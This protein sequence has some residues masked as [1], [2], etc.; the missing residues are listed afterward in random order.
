LTPGDG[1][2]IGA[3]W[4]PD[5]KFI[6]YGS[7]RGDKFGIYRIRADS[8]GPPEM[9]ASTESQ[10]LP[11]S[12]TPDD[13]TLVYRQADQGKVQIWLLS[14]SVSGGDGKPRRFHPESTS[15]EDQPQVSPDGK[16][17]AY[18]S[19]QS[20]RYE[21]Y[22]SPFPGP[23]GKFPVS[24]QGGR[25][26]V[27]SRS[28][29]ELFYVELNPRRMMAVAVAPGASF[30]AGR[31]QPLFIIRN[32]SGGAGYDVSPDGKRFL[33]GRPAETAAGSAPETTFI[34]VTDWF[35]DLLRRVPVKR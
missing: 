24:T 25:L 10:P 2:H 9:L 4:T 19:D 26:P 11:Y 21:I 30:Q 35:T 34:T 18:T 8:S 6:T 32:D 20:G 7:T 13:K 1:T 28:S 22:V 16:W 23:G 3:A 12:W 33:V 14:P 29:R 27:W 31:P 17:L 5:G 15:V